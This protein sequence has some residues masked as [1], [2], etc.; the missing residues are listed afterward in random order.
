MRVRMEWEEARSRVRNK[1]NG[2]GTRKE[3]EKN[4][5][6]NT[7][8]TV[9]E[10]GLGT[11]GGTKHVQRVLRTA[12]QQDEALMTRTALFLMTVAATLACSEGR[13]PTAPLINDPQHP[14]APSTVELSGTVVVEDAGQHRAVFL[15]RHD[16]SLLP[17]VG[18]EAALIASVAGGEVLVRGTLDAAPGM[19]VE[20]FQVLSMKGREAIDGVLIDDGGVLSLR[21]GNGVL[22]SLASVQADLGAHIGCRLWITGLD[23]PPV[24]FGIIE[25]R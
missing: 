13:S 6:D 22:R 8:W 21:L 1:W 18:S 23:E 10:P 12:P 15:Q 25:A 3:H 20:R 2:R 19:I 16:G 14:I 7:L 17:L 9:E 24:E 11:I 5:G 4:G